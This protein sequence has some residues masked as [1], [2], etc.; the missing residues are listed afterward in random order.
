MLSHM[1]DK[2]HTEEAKRGRSHGEPP[3][4]FSESGSAA[5]DVSR[6]SRNEGCGKRFG[7]DVQALLDKLSASNPFNSSHLLVQLLSATRN[8][9]DPSLLNRG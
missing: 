6:T 9:D 8:E 1:P 7:V 2:K 5:G 4:A 3:T